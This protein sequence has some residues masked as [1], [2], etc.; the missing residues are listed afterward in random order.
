ME[1]EN[2]TPSREWLSVD[3]AYLACQKVG[4]YR[5]KKTIR[6]WCRHEHVEAMKQT[7]PTGERWMVDKESLGVKI[8]SELEFQ[9]QNHQEHPGSNP[10]E[11]VQTKDEPV[12]TSTNPYEQVRAGAN[13]G[14][15]A[16]EASAQGKAE[17][18]E[19]RTQLRSLEIDKAVRDRQIEFLSQQN[20]E[21][22]KSL[23]SQ[24]RYIGH[25]ETQVHQLGGK[26]D[27]RFLEAPVAREPEPS[28]PEESPR[29]PHQGNLYNVH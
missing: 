23:L 1:Y 11:P 19:L 17:M 29:N 26:P 28:Q 12:R 14:E 16:P 2:K 27:Q 22:Q 7:T 6:S 20:E 18:D 21:G 4:L 13:Q 3:D 24:S 10:F 8:R 15:P 25:L 9:S 5:T